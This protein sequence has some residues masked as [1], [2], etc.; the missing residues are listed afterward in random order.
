[1]TVLQ[2]VVLGAVQ[3]ITEFLPISSSGH[4]IIVPELLGWEQQGLTFDLIV[5]LAT[6]LA[7][8]IALRTDLLWLWDGWWKR[9]PVR[10]RLTAK[11]A[12]ATV[13]ALVV[14]FFSEIG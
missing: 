11:L 1:M 14:G 6:L 10:L 7:V 2:A 3:G 12:A 4:L 13:P 5:H 9:D 8:I